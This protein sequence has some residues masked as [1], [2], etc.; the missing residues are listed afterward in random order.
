MRMR[1]GL[2]LSIYAQTT[3]GGYKNTMVYIRGGGELIKHPV[4]YGA[5]LRQFPWVWHWKNGR[6]IRFVTYTIILVQP[7]LFMI[8]K[9]VNSPEN[10]EF[11]TQKREARKHNYFAKPKLDDDGSHHH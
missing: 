9:A 5:A 4:Q 10:W 6:W 8:T 11:W 3:G 2:F 7:A 1:I